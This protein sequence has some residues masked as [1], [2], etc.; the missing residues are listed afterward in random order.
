[1]A[2]FIS[3]PSQPSSIATAASLAVPTPAST[4]T[5]TLGALDDQA[6]G[7]QV[8]DAEARTDRRAQR[9]DR[10]RAG[11]LQ[12][13]R[14]DRIVDAIDHRL[15]A[16]IGQ[17]L[18][19]AQRFAHVRIERLGLAQHL[20]LDQVPAARLARQPQRA[21][22]LLGGEAAGGVGQVGDLLRIDIIRPASAASGSL[23]LTRRTAT[24]TISAPDASTAAAFC[25]KSLYFPVPTISREVKVRPATVHVSV[26]F[27]TP[28]NEMDDLIS[29]AV[30]DH[31]LAK[32]RARDD[33]QVALDRD[34]Q[35][36]QPDLGD[37]L[38][39]AWCRAGTRRCSPLMITPA[40]PSRDIRL[41]L[42]LHG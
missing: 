40:V 22:R 34:P 33:L 38:R 24:V 31:H 26:K 13:L 2:V 9:H 4:S 27:S 1:M 14:G 5:G 29:V 30:L 32:G 7:D 42:S 6:D 21:D 17:H 25:S 11:F 36:I 37:Q 35:R 18:G 12:L 3:T 8:L 28:A 10:H 16:F 39:Q 41:T 20:Q 15:E 19:R 23:I